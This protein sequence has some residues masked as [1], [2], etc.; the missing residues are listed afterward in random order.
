MNQSYQQV[1]SLIGIILQYDRAL[2]LLYVKQ[3]GYYVVLR[4]ILV[5][6]QVSSL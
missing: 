4:N 3:G 6:A 2:N 5:D 1:D